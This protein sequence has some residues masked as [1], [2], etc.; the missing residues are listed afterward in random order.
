[1]FGLLILPGSKVKSDPPC[2]WDWA[3]VQRKTVL[4]FPCYVIQRTWDA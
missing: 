1:M 4:T 3:C 2:Q